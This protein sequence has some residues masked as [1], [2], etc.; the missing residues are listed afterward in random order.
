MKVF[1]GE[2]GEVQPLPGGMTL[3]Q[4]AE[5]GRHLGEPLRWHEGEVHDLLAGPGARSI[6]ATMRA[7]TMRMIDTPVSESPSRMAA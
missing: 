3:L 6:D 1:H 5:R 4:R 2:H 7:R